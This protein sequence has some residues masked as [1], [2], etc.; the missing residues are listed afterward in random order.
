MDIKMEKTK[1]YLQSKYNEAEKDYYD[2]YGTLEDIT[3]KIDKYKREAESLQ[4]YMRAAKN[5]MDEMQDLLNEFI[6]EI[7]D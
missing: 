7:N 5:K 2:M 4:S 1:K 6:H 3:K